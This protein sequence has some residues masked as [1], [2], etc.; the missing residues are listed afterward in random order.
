MQE[1]CRIVWKMFIIRVGMRFCSSILSKV[2]VFDVKI[3]DISYNQCYNKINYRS[4]LRPKVRRIAVKLNSRRTILVGLAFLSICTFWQMYDSVMTLILTDTFKLNET[5]AGAIMAADNVL[6]LFLLPFFGALSDK[7]STRIGRRMPFIVGGTAAAAI[8]MNLIPLLDDRYAAS[9]ST[10]TLV[11]F[12]IVL[13]LLLVSMGT[14][15]SP[16]V[17]LMPDVTPKPLRSRANAIINLMG[18]VGGILYLVITSV[19]YSSS[20]VAGLEHV[21]Y[22]PLFAIV[23]GIMAVSVGILFAAIREK[24]LHEENMALEAEHP[25][26]NLAEVD[27]SGN[28]KLPSAVRRS[29]GFLLASIA[30]W[31]IG[32]NAIETWFTTFADKMW[33]MALGDATLCLTIATAGAICSYIPVGIAASRVGRRRTILFGVLLL[34]ACFGSGYVYTLFNN[35]FHPALYALFALVGVAWASINVNSLPMVVEMCKGSDVGK[36]T[37]YY[38]TASMA[39][40]TITPI[41]AGWL[42]KHVSY[43]VLFLYSAIFVGLAFFTMLMVRHGDVK[44]EAKRGLEAFDVD[45]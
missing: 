32:Y 8:L 35:T 42:L 20:R 28:E 26:W 18:A 30:L 36:F 23:A 15:R 33:G 13:G 21:N 14:Y 41:V 38:Y 29:L 4:Q 24:K 40:Q 39:A 2:L 16:A 27:E 31:F 17:A 6:A 34:T 1:G 5:F 43:S 11:L 22:L 9:P 12:I 7:T 19:L 25:E 3:V 44:V 10:G 45:D 37:G